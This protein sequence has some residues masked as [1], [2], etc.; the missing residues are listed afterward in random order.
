MNK[1]IKWTPQQERAIFSRGKDIL[2]SASAGSGKTT[3]MIQRVLSLLS[4]GYSLKDMLIITFTRAAAADMR[5]KVSNALSVLCIDPGLSTAQ[6]SRFKEELN[7]LTDAD[8]S[9][10]HGWCKKLIESYFYVTAADPDFAPL[11]DGREVLL[12]KAAESAVKNHPLSDEFL[13]LKEIFGDNMGE[14]ALK[15]LIMRMVDAAAISPLDPTH[16]I[17]PDA[18]YLSALLELLRIRKELLAA[19]IDVLIADTCAAGFKRNKTAVYGLKA[20]AEEYCLPA[21]A[22]SGRIEPLFFDLNERFKALKDRVKSL[23]EDYAEAKNAPPQSVKYLRVLYTLRDGCLKEFKAQKAKK[24]ALDFNDMERYALEILQSEAGAEIRRRY[25]F[26]FVDE[27]QDVNPLQNEIISLLRCDEKD[28]NSLFLVGDLKQSIYAFRGCEPSIFAGLYTEF[29][30]KEEKCEVIELNSNH[31]SCDRILEF[32]NSVF[33]SAFT[34]EFGGVD[35]AKRGTFLPSGRKGGHA[36]LCFGGGI[37]AVAARIARILMFETV[38]DGDKKRPAFASDIAVLIRSGGNSERELK[39]ELEA[40][41]IKVVLPSAAANAHGALTEYLRLINNRFC[42]TALVN[43]LKSFFGGFSDAELA[44][45]RLEFADEESFFAAVERYRGKDDGLSLKLKCFFE[46]L[47]YYRGLSQ[48]VTAAELIGVLVSK[49]NYFQHQFAKGEAAADSLEE[50]LCAAN[51]KGRGTLAEFLDETVS[52]L[53]QEKQEDA[54]RVMTAHASKG[55]EFPFVII[56]S[57]EK[58]FNLADIRE[59]V[60]GFRDSIAIKSYDFANAEVRHSAGWLYNKEQLKKRQT[61]EELRLL[62]VAVTRAKY[63]LDIFADFDKEVTETEFKPPEEAYRWLDWLLPVYAKY[64]DTA[65]NAQQKPHLV[66]DG[67]MLSLKADGKQVVFPPVN[68]SLADAL[69]KSFS[70]DEKGMPEM[71]PSKIYVT[72]AAKKAA[73]GAD[74]GKTDTEELED[75]TDAPVCFN[76]YD[77]KD[78]AHTGNLYHLAMEHINFDAD[79]D[80]EWECLNAEVKN[81]VDKERIKKAVCAMRE[82]TAGRRCFKEQGFILKVCAEDAGLVSAHSFRRAE[83]SDDGGAKPTVLMQGIVDLIALDGDTAV[84]VDY[85][86]GKMRNE[87]KE[88]M[89]WYSQAVKKVLGIKNVK[90]CLYMFKEN[91]VIDI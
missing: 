34:K 65:D 14:N 20:A 55:L 83:H 72:E 15:R 45:I 80:A 85:K 64:R 9:T 73:A 47:D 74:A 86:T 12:A 8:I 81:G 60:L 41:G 22:P 67:K 1:T 17:I 57:A 7:S 49:T 2:V 54:V 53:S 70:R 76:E 50:Y 5:E 43:S 51:Q 6:R 88:Q 82:L 4:E 40:A 31:R 38:E 56:L 62:Y 48:S 21:R 3:V 79:F 28:G 24:A 37:K 89:Y 87:Y 46:R 66:G 18:E 71:Y 10:I 27:Y 32:A 52:V 36:G 30:A 29:L 69:K 42:D 11:E 25:K 61:E 84:I 26:I 58:R 78:A 23:A 35:Y 63:S 68:E 39:A 44:Q 59:P 91:R 33:C 90:S 13:E 77:N 19:R 16:K 75:N